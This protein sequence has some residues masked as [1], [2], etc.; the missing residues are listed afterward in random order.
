VQS[1]AARRRRIREP[2]GELLERGR[3][4][5]HEGPLGGLAIGAGPEPADQEIQR[6]DVGVAR[7]RGGHGARQRRV[8]RQLEQDRRPL[9]SGMDGDGLDQ[10]EP[11]R[12]ALLT[13]RGER[14]PHPRITADVSPAELREV[15]RRARADLRV[16]VLGRALQRGVRVGKAE[17][18]HRGSAHALRR[19]LEQALAERQPVAALVI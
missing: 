12:V 17:G 2:R 6:G 3:P 18:A 8:L 16:G 13:F 4:E 19:V 7:Q 15:Q 5:A 1:D 10:G 14:L 9:G 11:Q